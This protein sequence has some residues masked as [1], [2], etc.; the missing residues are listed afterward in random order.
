[1]DRRQD[2]KR[3]GHNCKVSKHPALQLSNERSVNCGASDVPLTDRVLWR[4][5]LAL[6]VVSSQ[7]RAHDQT[8]FFLY[9][10]IG[11]LK[12]E[13]EKFLDISYRNFGS[14]FFIGI[15]YKNFL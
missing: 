5:K 6:M 2:T 11:I 13:T 4:F 1:M 15:S 7:N 8:F 14:K 9:I 12:S 3:L 10:Y